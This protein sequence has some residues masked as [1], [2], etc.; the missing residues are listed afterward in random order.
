MNKRLS[1]ERSQ[2]VSAYLVRNDAI[3]FSNITSVGHGYNSPLATNKTVKGK[4]Q[5]R[6]VDIIIDPQILS[7]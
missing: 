1:L 5:N 4:A 7:E 6:R 2:A 3:D